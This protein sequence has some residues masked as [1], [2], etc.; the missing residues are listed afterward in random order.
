MGVRLNVPGREII[1]PQVAFKGNYCQCRQVVGGFGRELKL[2]G[3][4]L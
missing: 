4:I 2:F 3:Y 1:S